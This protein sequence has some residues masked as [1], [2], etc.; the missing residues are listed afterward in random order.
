MNWRRLRIPGLVA[1]GL[2]FALAVTD[3]S[4][5]SGAGEY[6][7]ALVVALSAV[8]VLAGAL[9]LLARHTSEGDRWRPTPTER[10]YRVPTPGDE[11]ASLRES[12]RKDRL[13]RR[14]TASLVERGCSP[15]EAERRL[16]EGSWTDDAIAAAYLGRGAV[17]APFSTRV[18]AALDGR[19][20]QDRAVERT[21]AA[22]R[23]L[24][25]G[26]AEP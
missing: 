22:L 5:A 4:L 8:G 2:G 9:S 10:G 23:D 16:E 25:A 12:E 19:S 3:V 14:V 24:R 20:I 7:Y 21:V 26:S 6:L 11:L 17:R 1:V 13:R 15:A 18:R